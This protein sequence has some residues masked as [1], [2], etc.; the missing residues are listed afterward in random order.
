MDTLVFSGHDLQQWRAAH[1]LQVRFEADRLVLA[2]TPTLDW[3]LLRLERADFMLRK[4]RLTLLADPLPG[5]DA[6][7]YIHHYGKLDVAEIA[8][9]GTVLDRGISLSLEVERRDDGALAIE[10]SFL[11]RHTSLSVG[12]ARNG[13]VY[14]GSGRDQYAIR[15]IEVALDDADALLRAVPDEERLRLI[16]VGG[17][18][19]LQVKWALHAD[20]ITPVLFEPNPAEA[21]GLRAAI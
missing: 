13:A 14:Q 4:V 12:C 11:N 2:D 18:G 5:Q 21:A 8:P 16:D 17:A 15:A 7:I 3:H 1:G 9:D 20:R 19:G 6:N 10:A